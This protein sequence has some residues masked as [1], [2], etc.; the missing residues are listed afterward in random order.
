MSQ[1][2]KYKRSRKTHYIF[3]SGYFTYSLHD[4]FRDSY[5]D[6]H[7]VDEY[8]VDLSEVEYI[9]SSALG[10]LL[11]LKERAEQNDASVTIANPSRQIQNV[12]DIANF[13]K[14]FT[15]SDT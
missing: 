5:R 6:T 3:V 1:Q 12:L 13:Y 10:M 2:I 7:D 15:I 9:D 8:I 11:L 14:F 4:E